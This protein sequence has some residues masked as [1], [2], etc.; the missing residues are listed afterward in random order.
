MIYHIFVFYSRDERCKRRYAYSIRVQYQENPLHAPYFK[1]SVLAYTRKKIC[2]ASLVYSR[3]HWGFINILNNISRRLEQQEKSE[4][5]VQNFAAC[6]KFCGIWIS[7]VKLWQCSHM[8]FLYFI[9]RHY[10]YPQ[11]HHI[12][13]HTAIK[14]SSGY[15]YL[16]YFFTSFRFFEWKV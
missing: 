2:F 13:I 1:C 14:F 9:I 16:C 12:K 10:V 5:S 4:G 3:I 7:F 11:I 15:F 8:L 6:S